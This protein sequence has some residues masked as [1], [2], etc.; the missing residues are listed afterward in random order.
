MSKREEEL[1]N[2]SYGSS[3]NDSDLSGAGVFTADELGHK[4]KLDPIVTKW[5]KKQPPNEDDP[6]LIL[7]YKSGFFNL[8]NFKYRKDLVTS[9]LIANGGQQVSGEVFQFDDWPTLF[10][11]RDRMIS[12]MPWAF[13]SSYPGILQ[14]NGHQF[15]QEVTISTTLIM[16]YAED[17]D[18]LQQFPYEFFKI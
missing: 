14:L 13:Y 17:Q 7:A 4:L 16:F 3:S 8:E 2:K 18:K 1:L 5:L 6:L 9:S 10:N 15:G 12:E 11:A